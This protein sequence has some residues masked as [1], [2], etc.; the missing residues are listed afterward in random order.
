[1]SSIERIL[2]AVVL[3]ASAAWLGACTSTTPREKDFDLPDAVA[4]DMEGMA[5]TEAATEKS[6]DVRAPADT[7]SAAVLE[8]LKSR[9]TLPVV[10]ARD[11]EHEKQAKAARADFDRALTE[12]KKGNLDA[13]LTQF[14][15]LSNQYPALAGPVVNQAILLR[16]KGQLDAAHELLQNGLL[17]HG[18]NPYYLNLLGIYS[19]EKGQ[20]KKA[21]TSYE[22]AIRIDPRYARAHYNLAVLADLYLHDPALA[23]GEFQ[24]YQGLLAEPDPKVAG[25]IKEIERRL[26]PP[27]E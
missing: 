22:S 21:R 4:S 6:T 5:D 17:T 10:A 1:M 25:W 9:Q 23:L 13:A 11:P 14:R 27:S 15:Q 8:R 19:R 2:F 26:T 7:D 24:T 16:K 12:M 20:F 3:I 18:R